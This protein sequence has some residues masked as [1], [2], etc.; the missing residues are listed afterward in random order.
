[1]KKGFTLIEM[2]VVMG[3]IAV[4]IAAIVTSYGAFV[5]RANRVKCAEAVSQ[6]RTALEQIAQSEQGW[7]PIIQQK[8]NN[9]DGEF[10]PEVGAA[11]ARRNTY[12][13]SYTKTKKKDGTETYVLT[14]HDR[15]GIVSPWAMEFI[16]HNG[17]AGGLTD[18]AKLPNG[19]TI[20]EHRFH[21]AIDDDY[22]GITE[23]ALGYKGGKARVRAAACVWCYGKDGKPGT[24]DDVRSW[25]AGQ[26]EK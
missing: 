22:D 12:S 4:L 3:I 6:V 18:M 5:E 19:S 23:V 26:E 14:G 25:S 7:P 8:A 9:G 21:Y 17:K 16:K 1:M 10:L 20:R 15:F 24:K 11:F 13:L 2:L